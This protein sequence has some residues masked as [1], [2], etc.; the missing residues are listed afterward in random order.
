MKCGNGHSAFGLVAAECVAQ[1]MTTSPMLT[2]F[3]TELAHQSRRSV[4]DADQC[5][6]VMGGRLGGS[7]ACAR[8]GYDR[9]LPNAVAHRTH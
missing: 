4:T 5:Y 2:S 6:A 3:K 1:S 8:P 7:T 9:C